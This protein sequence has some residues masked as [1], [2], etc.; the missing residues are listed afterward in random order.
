MFW[1]SATKTY[2]KQIARFLLWVRRKLEMHSHTSFSPNRDQKFQ[3]RQPLS[4]Q[5]YYALGRS[6]QTTEVF[7]AS[8]G[9]T[10]LGLPPG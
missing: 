4:E 6:W 2:R 3:T 9:S 10:K 8:T 7:I 1:V 5:N